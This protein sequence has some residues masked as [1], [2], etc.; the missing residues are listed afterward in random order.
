MIGYAG[1]AFNP[2]GQIYVAYAG[3]DMNGGQINGGGPGTALAVN[4]YSGYFHGQAGHQKG[5]SA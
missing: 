4:G 1:H 3:L 5:H 2:T